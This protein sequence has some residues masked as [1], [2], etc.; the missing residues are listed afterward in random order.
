MSTVTLGALVYAF[1]EEHL[2]AQK[3]V[4]PATVK[5]YRD[6]LRLFLRFL[7]RE[8]RGKITRLQPEELTA[9]RVRQFLTC[10][11]TERH[12]H[13]RSRNQ[14]LAALKAF[15]E[16]LAIERPEH[17]AEAERV[18]ALPVKRAPPPPTLFLERDEIQQVFAHLPDCGPYALRD[19]ALLLLLYNTGARVQEVAELRRRHLEL[20]HRRVH[21]HGKGDKWRVCPLWQ[22]SV[23]L[24][25]QLLGEPPQTP[26]EQPLF[27][28]QRG[29]ALT[30]FGIYKIV[31]RHTATLVKRG[32]D[33][34]PKVISP[35]V[36][37]HTAAVHLL[38]AGVEVNVIRA[39]LGHVSLETTNR[40]AEINIA[41]KEAAL[42]ACAPP[43]E[44]SAEHR[45]K[46]IWRDD[47]SLL[48]WL[49]SL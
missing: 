16:Y 46:P 19:R 44:V 7:A 34:E 8:K 20:D 13:I 3:G 47:P 21:L 35:H 43:N 33:G 30:R 49:Q 1:F 17:L 41:L 26:P 45:A 4:S 42:Q 22:E 6:A 36:L 15:F 12:N 9:E 48:K 40:Y 18:M 37:R 25:G 23:S 24:L 32:S 28:S 27:I 38:E 10:L 5:S 39:W 31:R 2:K 29:Q 11:E 14:R